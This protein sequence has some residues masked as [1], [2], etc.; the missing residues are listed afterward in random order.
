MLSVEPWG[1]GDADGTVLR[2]RRYRVFTTSSRPILVERLPAFL[3]AALDHYQT[4]LT[5]NGPR[6]PEPPTKLDTYVMATRPQ[7]ATLTRTLMR[8][9]AELYLRIQRGGFAAAGRGVYRDLGSLNDTLNLAAHEGWHQ[10]TQL[11]F[12]GRLP[13]YLEEGIATYMEGFRWDDRRPELAVFLPW[14]NLERF[15]TLRAAEAAGRL[16]PLDELVRSSPQSLIATDQD[17]ALVWYAQVWALV[18][19]LHEGDGGTHRA[20]LQRLLRDT[21]AGTSGTRR[22]G[23]RSDPFAPYFGTDPMTLDPAYQAFVRRITAPGTQNAVTRGQ[24]PL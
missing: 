24:S 14:A 16:M 3:E 19:F 6:L 8:D 1:F 20:G 5:G 21:A 2:T 13:I 4:S 23:R 18:H 17:A 9:R 11:A 22:L 7:W 12:R 10:Y 15:R